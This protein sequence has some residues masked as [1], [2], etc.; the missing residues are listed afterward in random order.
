MAC[1]MAA[2][3]CLMACRSKPVA[4]STEVHAHTFTGSA[5]QLDDG[6]AFTRF[7]D[8]HDLGAVTLDVSLPAGAFDGGEESQFSFFVIYDSCEDL[9]AGRKP[10][11]SFCTG[12]E[13]NIPK[14]PGAARALARDG[15]AWRLRG[16]FR[17]R[18]ASG[19]HQGLLSV[20]LTPVTGTSGV[21]R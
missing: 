2:A 20:E 15:E 19:Q 6:E 7:I 1:A 3:V 16:Q 17:V 4:T 11:Q 13:Y 5:G 14:A 12:T 10:N 18:H 9:P 8:A 21:V